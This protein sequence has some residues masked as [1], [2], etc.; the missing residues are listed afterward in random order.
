MA[1][2]AVL[3]PS[4][5]AGY[6]SIEQRSAYQGVPAPLAGGSGERRSS[7]ASNSTGRGR[8]RGGRRGSAGYNGMEI[9]QPIWEKQSNESWNE[10]DDKVED[11]WA[12]AQP[13]SASAP[14]WM[15]KPSDGQRA[16]GRGRGGRRGR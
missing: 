9:E 16:R 5:W 8:G 3:P 7:A 15:P 1:S 4:T 14:V 10:D 6:V 12:G 13:Y 11:D 2:I